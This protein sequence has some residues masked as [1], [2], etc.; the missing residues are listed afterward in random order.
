M[1]RKFTWKGTEIAFPDSFNWTYED[2][3]TS[4]TGRTLSAKMQKS[5][6]A[7][8]RTLSCGWKCL[9]DSVSSH[10]L[11][12][13][14]AD[15]YGDLNFPDPMEGKNITRNFYSGSPQ[16]TMMTMDDEVVWDITLELVER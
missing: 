8:K 16:A 6:V 3:S 13:I 1:D 12:T 14:K 7:S 4:N 11:K 10:L 5:I 9:P 15:T 2:I